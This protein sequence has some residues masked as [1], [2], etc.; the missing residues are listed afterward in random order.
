VPAVLGLGN[1]NYTVLNTVGT[2]TIN[3]GQASGPPIGP[4]VFYGAQ[5]VAAGTS[6]AV[7]VYDIV[8]A[9]GSVASSTNTLLNG[10][11]TAFQQ[12]YA[13]VQGIGIRY[14]GALVTVT[15]GTAGAINL[16]W[17]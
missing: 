8:P 10:T 4:G 2:T 15:T 3:A 11:G 6:F 7:T 12:F 9:T 13:G 17:D 1:C 14:K 16:L 5:Q